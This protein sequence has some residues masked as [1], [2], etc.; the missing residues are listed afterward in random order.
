MPGLL[1]AVLLIASL[2]LVHFSV[3][4]QPMPAPQPLNVDRGLPLPEAGQASTVFSLTALFGAYLGIYLIL[5]IPAL[6]GIAFGT[7]TSLFTIRYWIQRSRC[8][9]FEEFLVG[10]LNGGARNAGAFAIMVAAVQCAYATSE[11]LLLREISR[12]LLGLSSEYATLLAI[13]TGLIGYFYVLFGGYLAVY[14]TDIVQLLL[15]GAMAIVFAS[16]F[17][18]ID[19][20]LALDAIWP[21]PGYW[22]IPFV[23]SAPVGWNYLFQ[24]MIGAV[25]G[26]GLLAAAPD[27][28]KRVFVVTV[29][30]RQTLL[31]FASFVGIGVLPF[32]FLLPFAISTPPIPDGPLS[33]GQMF[34]GLLRNEALF[35]A[36]ALGLIASF[37][38]AFDSAVLAS[39]HVGLMLQRRLTPI[40]I[41]TPRFHWLMVTTL[42]TIFFLFEAL[43]SFDNPYL[44]ANLLLGPYAIVAGM[45]TATNAMPSRLPEGSLLWVAVLGFVAW[46]IYLVS[47]P[48]GLSHVPNTYEANSV[49]G[50]VGI[51][52]GVAFI[53]RILSAVSSH[54][55]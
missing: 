40:A 26:Y 48:V 50:G 3:H 34:S 39:V 32:L 19:L 4:A 49:V 35:V 31:R 52:L 55:V 21:R 7:V 25:M 43:V 12:L 2:F 13:A 46:F 8:S 23:A 36:A 41:E 45:L 28:W 18:G 42:I 5:G 10:I 29:F 47:S 30:R 33:V 11:L 53:C 14:R 24:F 1:I 44:L 27:A 37:L 20:S 54:N 9:S 38:S 22:E 51:F 16:Q 6:T 15:V 17:R